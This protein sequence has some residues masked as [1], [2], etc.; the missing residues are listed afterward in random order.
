MVQEGEGVCSKKRVLSFLVAV[1]AF[2]QP[3]SADLTC[4]AGLGKV[5]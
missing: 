5:K 2:T 1:W 4:Y 3:G